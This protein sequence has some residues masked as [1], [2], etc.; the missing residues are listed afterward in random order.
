MRLI[1][2]RRAVTTYRYLRVAIPILVVVLSASVVH[3]VFTADPNC[4][5][6]SISAYYY[7]AV[8][9]VFVATLCAI[10]TSLIVL[11]GNTDRE[12]LV[13]D[14]TGFLAYLVAFIPTP[15]A[16][17]VVPAEPTCGRSNVPSEEQLVAAIDNNLTAVLVGAAATLLVLVWFQ[18]AGRVAG[19]GELTVATVLFAVLV[20]GVWWLFWTERELVRDWGHLAAA[21][22]MFAGIVLVVAMNAFTRRWLDP[23]S[24]PARAPYRGLYRIILALMVLTV[25]VLGPLALL[26]V[27]DHAVFW[28]EALLI[29]LFGLFWVVQTQELWAVTERSE[30]DHD[31]RAPRAP[32]P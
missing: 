15:L 19:D 13:L 7:T 12:D 6:G 21:V 1:G 11:R 24:R 29:V 16:D 28:L 27:V 3:Q 4:W 14:V 8:R 25:V 18:W 32:H 10:G 20:V 30:L 26:G 22:V 17:L 2:P 23:Q 9:A 5:L 31:R